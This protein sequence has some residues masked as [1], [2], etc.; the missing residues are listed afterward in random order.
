MS[1]SQLC[2][3]Q[4]VP[5][6]LNRSS[7]SS[8][9]ICNAFRNIWTFPFL[10]SSYPYTF[11]DRKLIS[12]EI[13]STTTRALQHDTTLRSCSASSSASDE[14]SSFERQRVSRRVWRGWGGELFKVWRSCFDMQW[15]HTVRI[16]LAQRMWESRLV[17]PSTWSEL[18][19]CFAL[20]GATDHMTIGL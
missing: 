8:P 19:L 16:R 1:L 13:C 11:L 20:L 18:C 12:L 9:T 10:H 6:N 4:R 3:R 17:G 7:L 5:L 14:G 15:L 2:F